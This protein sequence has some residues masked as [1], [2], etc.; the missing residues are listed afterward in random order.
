M[1]HKATFEVKFRRRK[2]GRTDYK[3]RLELL[4]SRKPRL[5]IRRSNN[6]YSVQLIRYEKN[7]DKTIESASSKELRKYGWK[8]HGGNIQSA[9]LTGLLIG[10]KARNKVK[11][12]ILDI[13]MVTPVHGSGVFAALKGAIDSGMHVP[14]EAKALPS[15][16][17][18]KGEDKQKYFTSL[19]EEEFKEKFSSYVKEKIDP[20][21]IVEYFEEAKN[22]IMKSGEKK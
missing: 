15:E 8:L 16:N 18:I 22:K 4:K 12:A 10:V 17:R 20:K 21:K 7:G 6:N 9:Y 5:V 13:G 3:K 14:H 11:E 1:A 2:E 19:K